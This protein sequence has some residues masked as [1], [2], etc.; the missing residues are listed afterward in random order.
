MRKSRCTTG[1]NDTGGKFLNV[2]PEL[3][4]FFKNNTIFM[5]LYSGLQANFFSSKIQ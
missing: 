3:G 4:P 5:L 1:V 2:L